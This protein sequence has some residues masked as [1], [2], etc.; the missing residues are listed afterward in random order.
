MTASH[1]PF[2]LGWYL[3]RHSPSPLCRR[4]SM[5]LHY[6]SY[7]IRA[8]TLIYFDSSLESRALPVCKCSWH[9]F[10]VFI[11]EVHPALWTE[12]CVSGHGWMLIKVKGWRRNTD[13]K[14]SDNKFNI[15]VETANRSLNNILSMFSFV[16]DP[17]SHS[18]MY[19]NLHVTLAGLLSKWKHIMKAFFPPGITTLCDRLPS[20]QRC[21]CSCTCTT[22]VQI[23]MD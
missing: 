6:F 1:S 10:I 16:C 5:V 12:F 11:V 23:C 14:F 3:W 15:D 20:K 13:N 8:D 19:V 18:N 7:W 2:I 17:C 22:P 9:E 21:V 4:M